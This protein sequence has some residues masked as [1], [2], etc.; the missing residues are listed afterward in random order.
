[1]TEPIPHQLSFWHTKLSRSL[2]RV[3][4]PLIRKETAFILRHLRGYRSRRNIQLNECSETKGIVYH[5]YWWNFGNSINIQT[6]SGCIRQQYSFHPLH[7]QS[8]KSTTIISATLSTH[9][10]LLYIR[11]LFRRSIKAKESSWIE[12]LLYETLCPAASRSEPCLW[13]RTMDQTTWTAWTIG[14][15][16]RSVHKG[17]VWRWAEEGWLDY[18]E[19]RNDEVSWYLRIVLNMPLILR[20]LRESWLHHTKNGMDGI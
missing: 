14:W 4:N 7:R 8:F 6:S 2:V 19:G 5:R 13:L 12:Q 16:I 20:K 15:A 3:T 10:I 9:D 18:M 11:H 1:M 17:S